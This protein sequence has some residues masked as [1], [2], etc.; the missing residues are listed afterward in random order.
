MKKK[1][2]RPAK[3]CGG[4]LTDGS[5]RT[6]GHSAGWDTEHNGRGRCKFHGGNT[7][8][9]VK[10]AQREELAE[11]IVTFGLPIDIEPTDAML[12]EVHRTAGV[13]LFLEGE[14][15]KLAPEE[16]TYG[17][18]RDIGRSVAGKIVERV[19]ERRA[20][21]VALVKLWQSERR[22]MVNVCAKAIAA[23]IAERQVRVA[24]QHAAIFA[25]A[26][27]GMFEDLGV[28]DHPKLGK[29]VRRHLTLVQGGAA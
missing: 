10:A 25:A 9:H 6:C 8:T 17:I 16:L 20:G 14:V 29:I 27:R 15:R 18:H 28:A 13:V 7:P 26:L 3:L 4:K 1:R 24:E 11:A 12:D 5:G 22:H 21:V 2:K 23:G 19:V